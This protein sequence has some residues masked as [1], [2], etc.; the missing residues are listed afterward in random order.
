MW[1]N[2]L[3]VD[4]REN[5]MS[6]LQLTQ[7]HSF[8]RLVVAVLMAAIFLG[9]LGNVAGLSVVSQ[10]ALKYVPLSEQESDEVMVWCE[11][12]GLKRTLQR[13]IAC[14]TTIAPTQTASV[15]TATLGI[16]ISG[17]SY[18]AVQSPSTDADVAQDT[19]GAPLAGAPQ[20]G[21]SR[22]PAPTPPNNQTGARDDSSA[23][24]AV[25]LFYFREATKIA[26]ILNAVAS[27]QGSGSDLK[28]LII[29]NASEDEIILYGPKEKRDYARRIIATLDLPRPGIN[30]EMWGIQISSRKPEKM[31]EVMPRVREEINRTQQAVRETYDQLQQIAREVI[32]DSD[33]DSG[34]S[35]LLGEKLFYR[36]ALDSRRPLSLADILLRLIAAKEPSNAVS[37]MAIGLSSWLNSRY[38]DN[39]VAVTRGG[40]QPC[41]RFLNTRGLYY[42]NGQWAETNGSITRN[43]L[44]ARVALL[45]FALHYGSLVHQPKSFSPYFLQQSAETLNGRLQAALDALNLDMQE[46]F[47]A[48]TLA[49]IQTIVRQFKDVE[50]AQVGKTSVA[51]LSGISTVVT[52]HSVSAFDVTPPLRLSEL[53]AKAQALSTS[54]AP[55]TKETKPGSQPTDILV[56]SMPLAQVIGLIGALGE[57]R[58]VWRELQAGVSLTITP[59]VLRNMTS[60]ELQIDLKTGDPQAGTREQGVRP[61]SRVSQ[62]DVKTNVYINALDFFDL[63]AFASQSTLNGGRGYVPIIGTVWQGLFSEVPVLGKLFSWQKNPQ[64]VYNESL[65]LTNAFITPTVMGIAVLYP[66]ELSDPKTGEQIDYNERIF[67]SQWQEVERY[68]AG[69]Q[70]K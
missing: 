36:S 65:V 46:L 50:Y 53:L 23:G 35:Q 16:K 44:Q 43:V 41:E 47:V 40:K 13:C 69:L 19:T 56:G 60:A 8:P 32:P 51:S 61:L 52:S 12:C 67:R 42:I 38:P 30:M 14:N 59:N 15:E 58:S 2:S 6:E 9:L 24:Q 70:P 7:Y 68:K 26:A 21:A 34:F 48:P 57:E 17:N 28:G 63:S 3:R 22:S 1:N 54:A 37:R 29:T 64:T 18:V 62:H 25:R 10:A 66:T 20:S 11:T 49:R 39:V 31:A 27:Q 5:A 4:P 33:L 45:E 55:F